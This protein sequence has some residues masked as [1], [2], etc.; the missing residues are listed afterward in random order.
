ML[1]LDPTKM[2]DTFTS[3]KMILQ[4]VEALPIAEQKWVLTK[5]GLPEELVQMIPNLNQVNTAFTNSDQSLQS[6]ANFMHQINELSSDFKVL[7]IDIGAVLEN[8]F[9]GVI[10]KT[11]DG[12]IK[13]VDQAQIL[14]P[15]LGA[16]S[17]VLAVM[18]INMGK[19]ALEA[20]IAALPALITNPLGLAVLAGAV[21]GGV[22]GLMAANNDNSKN[23]Q[24]TNQ[25]TINGD[26]AENN[27]KALNDWHGQ[28]LNNAGDQQPNYN[29]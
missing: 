25:I 24:M 11:L 2:S 9:V 26:S 5:F 20:L 10:L 12:F 16:I 3:L 14:Y 21:G 13:F 23:V 6:M 1:H 27:V 17:G 15:L 28:I 22:L 18:A 19:I 8:S 29:Y 4:A 7:M